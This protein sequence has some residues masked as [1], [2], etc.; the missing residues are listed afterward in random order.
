[1]RTFSVTFLMSYFPFT[2]QLML[3]LSC[4]LSSVINAALP[5][6]CT[7]RKAEF[8]AVCHNSFKPTKELFALLCDCPSCKSPAD[9]QLDN[10]PRASK[11]SGKLSAPQIPWG[12]L[13]KQPLLLP[14]FLAAAALLP[15][16]PTL[17]LRFHRFFSWQKESPQWAGLCSRVPGAW[18]QALLSPGKPL[19]GFL[20]TPNVGSG[21]DWH[22]GPQWCYI[23]LYLQGSTLSRRRIGKETRAV[24]SSSKY[25]GFWVWPGYSVHLLWL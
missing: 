3:R 15:K 18:L 19:Q 17:L 21:S 20:P 1:M 12:E 5:S 6:L 25:Q 23:T 16:G 2:P 9:L 13:L 22:K 4:P 10:L 14:P 11:P 7:T 24:A 8:G